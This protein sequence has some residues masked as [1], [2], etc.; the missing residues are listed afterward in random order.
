M[1]VIFLRIEDELQEKLEALAIQ[2]D[3]SVNKYITRVLEAHVGS[4]V[5]PTPPKKIS[6]LPDGKKTIQFDSTQ[7]GKNEFH[8]LADD[9]N[10]YNIKPD[11]PP[12][13]DE[14][15]EALDAAEQKCCR[16]KSPCKHWQFDGEDWVNTLSGRK[17]EVEQ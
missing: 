3:R 13:S 12:T 16:L 4:L 5:I 15:K 17:R 1:K 10:S 14:F 8:R 11:I 6:D 2:D 9:G 7:V